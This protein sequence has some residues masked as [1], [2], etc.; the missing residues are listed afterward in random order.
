MEILTTLSDHLQHGNDRAARELTRQAIHQGVP[1]LEILDR[2]LLAGMAVVGEQFRE[3]QIFLPDVLLAARA[4]HAAVSV[5]KPHLTGCE[6]PSA[7][8]VVLGT[9]TGDMHDIGKN[10]VAIMLQ[11]AGFDVIDLGTDVLPEQFVDAAVESGAHVIGMSALLTT[12]M[13][14]ME[15][16]V[17]LV[18]DRGLGGRMATIVGGAPITTE[19]AREIGADAYGPDAPGAVTLIRALVAS[20]V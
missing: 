19:F 7:G 9:V 14:A 2:A 10:L 5:L 4:M 8:V 6:V 12:T 18:H 15:D 17:R 1:P 3:H 16:V 20:R 13:V 11:G